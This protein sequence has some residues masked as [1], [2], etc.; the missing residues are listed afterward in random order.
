MNKIKEEILNRIDITE[1]EAC[2]LDLDRV[3]LNF[4]ELEC[5][6]NN[7]D[8]YNME[9]VFNYAHNI[10]SDL[11]EHEIKDKFI[12]L[13]NN[14]EAVSIESEANFLLKKVAFSVKK[15]KRDFYKGQF[16]I[17]LGEILL[18]FIVIMILNIMTTYFL[19]HYA[20]LINA[21]IIVAI[22]SLFKIFIEKNYVSRIN[23]RKQKSFFKKSIH[24][25]RKSFIQM[26][27]FYIKI[28]RFDIEHRNDT[29]EVRRKQALLFIKKNHPKI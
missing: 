29:K 11:F 5:L 26:F 10:I 22:F 3:D 17:V 24:S 20:E 4:K 21:T 8:K 9:W 1:E 2:L 28:S 16:I 23:K 12:A 25:A 27:I 19:D 13:Q 14:T 7:L 15:N 6:E 18:S